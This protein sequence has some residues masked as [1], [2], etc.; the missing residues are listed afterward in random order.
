MSVAFEQSSEGHLQLTEEEILNLRREM[1]EDLEKI[2]FELKKKKG[3]RGPL[4]IYSYVE[5]RV[6]KK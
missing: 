5:R 4:G 2:L 6:P 3:P 1:M